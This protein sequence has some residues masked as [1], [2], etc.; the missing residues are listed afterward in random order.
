M[1]KIQ[2]EALQIAKK[3]DELLNGL[4]AGT[5]LTLVSAQFAHY[6]ARTALAC[7]VDEEEFMK[8]VRKAWEMTKHDFNAAVP[9]FIAHREGQN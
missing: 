6:A 1:T 5:D 3:L 4:E 2:E 8:G 7:Y 9:G